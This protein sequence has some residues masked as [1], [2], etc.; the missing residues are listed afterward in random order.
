MDN[1]LVLARISRCIHLHADL[2]S[3]PALPR[4]HTDRR[5]GTGADVSIHLLHLQRKR[6]IVPAKTVPRQARSRLFLGQVHEI[7][8]WSLQRD[9]EIKPG[10][11]LLLRDPLLTEE[12]WSPQTKQPLID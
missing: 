7:K 5:E 9:A 10:R 1:Q 8:S 6:D 12:V 2:E 11:E 3:F 4:S